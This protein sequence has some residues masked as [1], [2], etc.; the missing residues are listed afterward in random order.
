M[1]ERAGWPVL[2]YVC[3]YMSDQVSG[4]TVI[5]NMHVIEAVTDT[6]TNNLGDVRCDSN[7]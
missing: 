4:V 2:I 3:G 6:L 1:N 5:D 7:Q